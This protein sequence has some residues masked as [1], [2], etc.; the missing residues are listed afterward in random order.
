MIISQKKTLIRLT[1]INFDNVQRDRRG[2]NI[3]VAGNT[4]SVGDKNAIKRLRARKLS[5]CGDY[6]FGIYR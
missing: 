6:G 2:A 5:Y 4:F 1:G 3:I